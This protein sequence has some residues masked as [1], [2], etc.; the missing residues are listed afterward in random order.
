MVFLVLYYFHDETLTSNDT[1]TLSEN[2]EL[3]KFKNFF[4][5]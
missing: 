2:E 5:R 3:I 4:N 1:F